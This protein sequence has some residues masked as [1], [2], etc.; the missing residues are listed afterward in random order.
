MFYSVANNYN[1]IGTHA[2]QSVRLTPEQEV[3]ITFA[4][5]T[6]L[7]GAHVALTPEVLT[8]ESCNHYTRRNYQKPTESNVIITERLEGMTEGTYNGYLHVYGIGST[9]LPDKDAVLVNR[10]ENLTLNG[11]TWNLACYKDSIAWSVHNNI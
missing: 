11:N 2:I 5:N 6:S 9:K 10:P 4:R 7:W 1:Y 8:D 3:E